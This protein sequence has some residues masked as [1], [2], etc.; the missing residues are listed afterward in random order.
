MILEHAITRAQILEA[1]R[2][3]LYPELEFPFQFPKHL[4]HSHYSS[5]KQF[6]QNLNWIASQHYDDC[7]DA[8]LEIKGIS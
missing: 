1:I 2:K 7:F 6:N 5:K 8:L 4:K 3:E